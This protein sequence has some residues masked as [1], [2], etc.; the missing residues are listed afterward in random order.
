[1]QVVFGQLR[2]GTAGRPG[3]AEWFGSITGAGSAARGENAVRGLA[4]A[5]LAIQDCA[6]RSRPVDRVEDPPVDGP[7]SARQARL[8]HRSGRICAPAGDEHSCQRRV[9][10]AAVDG[11]R[12]VP[13]AGV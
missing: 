6:D 5:I 3:S 12:C 2:I 7:G 4:T 1:M 11:Q 8:R 13:A 10:A 9:C